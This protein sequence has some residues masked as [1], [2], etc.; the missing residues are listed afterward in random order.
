MDVT[1]QA[2]FTKAAAEG[3]TKAVIETLIKP[4]VEKGLNGLKSLADDTLDQYVSRFSRY[5]ESQHSRHSYLNTIVFGNKKKLEELYLPLTVVSDGTLGGEHK[6]YK[7]SG[8]TPSFLPVYKKVLITDTAGM[9]KSTLSKFLLLKC[10]ESSSGVPVF[11][12]LRQLSKEIPI[13]KFLTKQL[14]HEND[15]AAEDYIPQRRVERIVKNGGFCFFFDGYDEISLKER[16]SVTKDIKDFVEKFSGNTFALTSRPESGLASFPEFSRFTIKPLEKNESY[17]L[18]KKYDQDGQR[19]AQLIEKLEEGLFSSVEDFLKNPLLTTLLYRSFDYK[20]QIPL[21]KHTFYRQVFDALYDWHDSTKDGYN[22]REKKS[23]L[24]QDNFHKILRM[25][26]FI[27]LMKDRVEGDADTVLGW[28]RQAQGSCVGLK[29]SE[30]DFLDDLIK[31]VPVF[32]KD[33][34]YYRWSHKSLAE[35]F[36]AQYICNEGKLRQGEILK[37][38]V[39]SNAV[40]R[41]ENMLDQ[42]YDMDDDAFR[43]YLTWPTLQAF[44]A[45]WNQNVNAYDRAISAGEVSLRLSVAFGVN[46][47]LSNNFQKLEK[48]AV[49]DKKD[50]SFVLWGFSNMDSD[51]ERLLAGVEKD[52]FA[53]VFDILASKK[54]PLVTKVKHKETAIKNVQKFKWSPNLPKGRHLKFTHAATSILNSPQYFSIL[55]DM[56]LLVRGVVVNREKA[57]EFLHEYKGEESGLASITDELLG[58]LSKAR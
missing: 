18:I 20:Q 50:K 14:N 1:T 36:A 32:V 54:N 33:G 28:I 25:M 19:S 24:D 29:F 48:R 37:K 30:S 51:E 47:E 34:L 57:E 40:Y 15:S 53:L 35:Y 41:F 56:L 6:E 3:V 39:E 13:I 26:G 8:F 38:I 55:T 49:A 58:G 44:D 43:K 10:V 23:K 42:I 4:I 2:A 9:G 52:R 5:V 46:L 21:K 16:E 27:S 7:L 17:E 45:F 11:I 22:T 31:A 12:E